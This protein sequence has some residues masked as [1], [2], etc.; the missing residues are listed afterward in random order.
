MDHHCPWTVNCVS[1]RTFPHFVRFLFYAVGSMTQLEYFLYVRVAV[2]WQGRDLPSY[3]G[4][5][6]LQLI[7]LFIFSVVN[8]TTL[9]ALA[10]LLVRNIWCLGANVTTIEGW[11][12]ERHETLLRRAKVLG[13]YLDGPNGIKVKIDRQEFPYDIGIFKNMSQAMGGNGLFWLWPFARSLL[14]GDGL[15]FE[16][17][18]F[19]D[20]STSW[21]PP[22]PDRIPRLMRSAEPSRA[23]AHG[24]DQLS[25][26]E[27][28][29]AFR[30]RQVADLRRFQ[31]DATP[32]VRRIPFYDRY[33]STPQQEENPS[34]QLDSTDGVIS[35]E[36]GWRD[37][38]GDRLDDF[39]VDDFV[40]FYDEDNLPLATLLQQQR[41]TKEQR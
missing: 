33:E 40:E 29:E 4:P 24:Q 39:G 9:F 32:I 18:G 12:M 23:F 13:G 17:N 41:S 1:Y 31:K 22:D 2:V 11:E 34:Q 3:L 16:I 36:E 15:Q 7:I 25:V 27:Q 35:G 28:I 37:P 19:E 30:Q 21:P 8:S 14:N 10:I 5:S 20:P 6:P 38:E 26:R